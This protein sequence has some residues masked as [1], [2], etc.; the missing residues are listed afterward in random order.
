MKKYQDLHWSGYVPGH[1][2]VQ[3]RLENKLVRKIMNYVKKLDKLIFI[4]H[5]KYFYIS[6][7]KDYQS[8]VL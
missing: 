2:I 6:M 8:M 4:H 5:Y 7:T 1:Q 3:P